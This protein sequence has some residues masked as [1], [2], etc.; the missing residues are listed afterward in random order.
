MPPHFSV[1]NHCRGFFT[2]GSQQATVRRKW[3][4]S[5]FPFVATAACVPLEHF[6]GGTM[7]P[8][9]GS[10]SRGRLTHSACYLSRQVVVRAWG[11]QKSSRNFV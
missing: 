6:G 7:L 11:H 5:N 2:A 3:L 1:P 8:G 9:A 4:A 10:S